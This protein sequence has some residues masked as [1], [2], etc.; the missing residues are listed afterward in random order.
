MDNTVTTVVTTVVTIV[1]TAT[2][3]GAVVAMDDG[4]DVAWFR[5]VG[6]T[7]LGLCGDGGGDISGDVDGTRM[8]LLFADDGLKAVG[9]GPCGESRDMGCKGCEG[10]A[11][12]ASR[13]GFTGLTWTTH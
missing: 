6:D 13:A 9:E 8:G 12:G 5:M 10:G 2:I 11:G 7:I 4:A 1:V 3:N